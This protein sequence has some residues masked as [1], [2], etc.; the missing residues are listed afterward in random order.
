M[1]YLTK[2]IAQGDPFLQEL[3]ERM[4]NARSL[5]LLILAALQLGRAVVV[6]VA[7]EV[8]N[9]RGQAPDEGGVCPK[10]GKRLESNGLKSREVRALIGWVK[11]RRRVTGCQI[12][13]CRRLHR[14][15]S[16]Y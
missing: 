2:S 15:L 10:C 7:E 14:G 12:V 9:E 5:A 16:S 13:A 11:W 4:K 1:S 6:K 3:V 8:L